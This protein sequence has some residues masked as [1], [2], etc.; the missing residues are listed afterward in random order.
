MIVALQTNR[1]E[2]RNDIAEEIRLFLGPAEI[3]E[4]AEGAAYTFTVT[5]EARDDRF[6]AC[7]AALNGPCATAETA[8]EGTDRLGKFTVFSSPSSHPPMRNGI[9]MFTSASL[10]AV[11]D[12][13]TARLRRKSSARVKSSVHTCRPCGRILR[14]A[15][16]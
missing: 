8:M 11:Q 9:W 12:A 7:A 2:Y 6:F 3:V 13:C 10:F 15:R 16:I 4:V 14:L 1:P 5:L